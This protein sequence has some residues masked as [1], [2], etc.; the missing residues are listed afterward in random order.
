M[1]EQYSVLPSNVEANEK[2]EVSRYFTIWVTPMLKA[3]GQYLSILLGRRTDAPAIQDSIQFHM[4]SY[5]CPIKFYLTNHKQKIK[6]GEVFL[7]LSCSL[8]ILFQY[9]FYSAKSL[10]EDRLPNATTKRK[11]NQVFIAQR[12]RRVGVHTTET[13]RKYDKTWVGRLL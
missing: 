5:C 10:S 1:R 6:L 3:S 7:R 2:R 12:H 8:S 11:K 4:L 13:I 9:D